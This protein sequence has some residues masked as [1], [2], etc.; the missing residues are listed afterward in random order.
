VIPLTR[1]V[2]S[3]QIHRDSKDSGLQGQREGGKREL[4]DGCRVLV[5]EDEKVL[6][7]CF[8]AV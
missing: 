7:I 6:E 3:S 4:F 1:G 5:L 8:T 2:Q